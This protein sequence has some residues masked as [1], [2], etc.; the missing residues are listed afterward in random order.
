MECI[1]LAG[2]LGT[3]IRSSIGE[4]PKCMAPVAGQPF[5]YYLL[6]YLAHQG[7]TKAVL[8]LG[9]KHEVVTEWIESGVWPF[10]IEYSIEHEPLG[11]GG[12]ILQAMHSCKE[13]YVAVV[14]GDTYFPVN[15]NELLQ[16]GKEKNAACALALKEL[17][18]F[19][20]Y[21]LVYTDDSGHI[22]SFEEKRETEQGL[23]N[24]GVYAINRQAF[25]NQN[26]P[27]KFSFEKD[28]LEA[29]VSPGQLYGKAFDDY[30]LDIGIPEDYNKAQEDFKIL[31]P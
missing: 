23:I 24:G 28:F 4:M 17:H 3:R 13:D 5:L 1:I 14:N 25:L 2:G 12:A 21:G 6:Q 19:N 15:Q 7:C 11:T 9:Y 18:N 30:F 20:R 31:R 16:F 29:Q 26:L 10:A 8:A 22:Q 27:P